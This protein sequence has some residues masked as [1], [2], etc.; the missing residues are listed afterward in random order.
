MSDIDPA[1]MTEAER[2]AL[3]AS[4][5]KGMIPACPPRRTLIRQLTPWLSAILTERERGLDW[6]QLAEI[7]AT[8][9]NI[10]VSPSTLERTVRTLIERTGGRKKRRRGGGGS[11]TPTRPTDGASP[12]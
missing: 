12:A 5:T 1:K 8:N 7:C 11:G 6:K 4:F 9:L 3:F 10:K 2:R